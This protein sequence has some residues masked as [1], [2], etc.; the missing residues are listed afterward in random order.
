MTPVVTDI[1]VEIEMKISKATILE[2]GVEFD[3]DLLPSIRKQYLTLK[4]PDL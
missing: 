1:E 3:V 4:K 2:D